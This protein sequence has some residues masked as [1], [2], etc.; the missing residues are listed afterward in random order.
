MAGKKTI[1]QKNNGAPAGASGDPADPPQRKR[2]NPA[3]HFGDKVTSLPTDS[4]FFCRYTTIEPIKL[5]RFN[6]L[7]FNVINNNTGNG[8]YVFPGAMMRLTN[9]LQVALT[10]V[11]NYER[12]LREYEEATFGCKDANATEQ[13]GDAASKPEDEAETRGEPQTH[14][15]VHLMESVISTYNQ[16]KVILAVE[17]WE[18]GK[19]LGIYLKS[20]ADLDNVGEYKV[21]KTCRFTTNDDGNAL[22]RFCVMMQNAYKGQ[23]FTVTS[24]P[25]ANTEAEKE[26]ADDGLLYVASSADVI[27]DGHESE[28]EYEP[29]SAKMARI[30]ITETPAP[31]PSGSQDEAGDDNKENIPA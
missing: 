10:K 18:D 23:K 26:A 28:K 6:S 19:S 31:S 24:T 22:A 12:D 27:D 2:P 17:K 11:R 15:R 9:D 29:P 21:M 20:L 1:P 3:D 14:E 5:G 4:K 8:I 16:N 13:S 25:P 7:C 30:E